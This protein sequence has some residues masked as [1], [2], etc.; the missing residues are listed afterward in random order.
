MDEPLT[1]P[2]LGVCRVR[3]TGLF[4][5]LFSF[6]RTCFGRVRTRHLALAA[7]LGVWERARPQGDSDLSVCECECVRGGV[8]LWYESASEV[9][10]ESES[11]RSDASQ[12]EYVLVRTRVLGSVTSPTCWVTFSGCPIKRGSFVVG[13]LA[14][15]H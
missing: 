15:A 7:T 3:G 12:C 13:P 6:S 1:F 10:P 11:V 5:F 2:S 8:Q 14:L 4:F 9:N